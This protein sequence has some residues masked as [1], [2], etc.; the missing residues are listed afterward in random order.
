MYYIA[1]S[2]VNSCVECWEWRTNSVAPVKRKQ[3]QWDWLLEL[4]EQGESSSR[5]WFFLSIAYY[6]PGV[7]GKQITIIL[8]FK[9]F[10]P[11]EKVNG[12]DIII[13]KALREWELC[14]LRRIL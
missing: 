14:G 4:K 5:W 10:S 11:V 1:M 6:E 9:L 3:A 8:A 7:L 2:L 13:T 12:M